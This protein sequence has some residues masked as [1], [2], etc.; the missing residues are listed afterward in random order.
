MT[1]TL[2]RSLSRTSSMSI[3][4]SSPRLSLVHESTPPILSDPTLSH[5]HDRL[6]YLDSRLLEL[7]SSVL[8]KDGYVDR[9]N[10]EDEH[11]RREFEAN[12]SVSNRIDLNVVALK[13]DVDQL[14]SGISQLKSSIG[15]TGNETVFL[16]SD[17]DR[18]SKNVDQIQSDVEHLQT[19]VCGCRVEV[20]KLHATISQLR[21]DLITLQHETSRHLTSVFNRFSL[22]ESRMKHS[23]RVR[24][25]SL[26]HTT[27][28]PITPVPVVEDDGS[29]QWPEYFPR[30]V[31]RFWCLKKRSR[32]NRLVQLADFY[33][34]GGYEYWG[35]MHQTEPVYA[36][37]TDSDSSDSSDYPSTLTR[38]EAVRL[39]PEAAHQALAAT[40]GLV[41]YKI[42]NEVGE[43]MTL[44][45]RPPKRQ[46]EEVASAAS[47]A[48]EK[49]VK[50]PRR[51]NNMSP[52]TLKRLIDGPSLEAKSLTSEESDKLGWNAHSEVSDDTMSKLRG[53]V[54]EEVGTLLR[55]LER[56]R[57]KLR[58]TR[59]EQRSNVSP[60]EIRSTFRNGK[61][62]DDERTIPDTVAT[63]VVSVSSGVPE[64]VE[65]PELPDT[66]SDATSP[67][68]GIE[69]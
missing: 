33:Q 45:I 9:R 56:G 38:A 60:S 3:P 37:A 65:E 30:T 66:A 58:S 49:P 24:F 57:I 27:H 14:K 43:G 22:I 47:S 34:L 31:W 39:Y 25:N 42:R 23:E 18:L 51:P 19:D 2:E 44:H 54:S 68:T 35:R 61:I 26:A 55:A 62:A 8:T 36:T 4:V 21:T 20:S 52:T 46:Q 67:L 13:T 16:R 69:T 48:K 15:Q 17:V 41:Y 11:I 40:L 7:R 5:I 12:R 1:T 32:I 64:K 63:E 29:L 59:P 50:M 53:I 10:R 6:T 28:A